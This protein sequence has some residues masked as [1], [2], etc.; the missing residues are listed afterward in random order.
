MA[1]A[2]SGDKEPEV[3]SSH[4][5]ATQASSLDDFSSSNQLSVME[6]VWTALMPEEGGVIVSL[7]LSVDHLLSLVQ[8]VCK[9]VLFLVPPV[10]SMGESAQSQTETQNR[11]RGFYSGILL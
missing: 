7:F 9:A 8:S 4:P 3:V 10:L 5:A 1:F 11:C 6:T 2:L